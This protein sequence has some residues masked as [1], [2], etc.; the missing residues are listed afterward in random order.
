[1][2]KCRFITCVLLLNFI[3]TFSQAPLT[4]TATQR[5]NIVATGNSLTSG[6][7]SSTNNYAGVFDHSGMDWPSIMFRKL[8]NLTT[9]N[10]NSSSNLLYDV[11]NVS[12]ADQKTTEMIA[13]NSGLGWSST[14]DYQDRQFLFAWEAS[15]DILNSAV[16]EEEALQH[17]KTYCL[18]ARAHGFKVIVPNLVART[19]NFGGAY[20]GGQFETIRQGFN[21]RL[22]NEWPYFADGFVDVAALNLQ[23]TAG[24]DG[25]NPSD[26]GYELLANTFI[27]SLYSI[28]IYG[29][30]FK[31]EQ[32]YTLTVNSK[33]SAGIYTADNTF[34]HIF[35]PSCLLTF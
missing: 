18:K 9:A 12:Q 25:K 34:W 20:T 22:A 29:S 28:L 2:T 31:D 24:W 33:T 7:N 15:N 26:A 21:T 19:S 1:M 23:N 11:R 4:Y 13:T 5:I 32:T 17:L 3:N 8:N 16:S 35:C 27:Q 14:Y 30:G 6:L 10:A